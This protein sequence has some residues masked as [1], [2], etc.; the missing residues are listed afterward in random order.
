MTNAG[1]WANM[2]TGNSKDQHKVTSENFAGNQIAAFP[3]LFTRFKQFNPT[4][5]TTSIAASGVFNANLATDATNRQTFENDDAS[6]KSAVVTE[7]QTNDPVVL[8]AQFHSAESKLPRLLNESDE[9]I[10]PSWYK[11]TLRV[12][13]FEILKAMECHIPSLILLPPICV[14]PLALKVQLSPPLNS[15]QPAL[16]FLK[17]AVLPKNG[18]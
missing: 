11:V 6:V 18:G 5:R 17:S 3:S 12:G 13:E 8:V 10:T 7:L 15:T 4:L 1:G 9:P 14:V 16:P 2:L